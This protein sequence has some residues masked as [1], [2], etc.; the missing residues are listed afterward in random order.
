MGYLIK[1]LGGQEVWIETYA[2]PHTFLKYLLGKKVCLST[3]R[4]FFFFLKEQEEALPKDPAPAPENLKS[5]S[6][7]CSVLCILGTFPTWREDELLVKDKRPE[8]KAPCPPWRDPASS[9]GCSPAWG[10][11]DSPSQRQT[12]P[13]AREQSI[14]SSPIKVS[15]KCSDGRGAIYCKFLERGVKLSLSQS[16]TLVLDTV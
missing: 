4:L 11:G 15:N 2:Y 14:R 9:H 1:L 10:G 8:S 3:P 13:S 6:P 12:H 5:C 7:T 16:A